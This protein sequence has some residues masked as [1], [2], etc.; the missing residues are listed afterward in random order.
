MNHALF[1]YNGSMGSLTRTHIP[2]IDISIEDVSLDLRL[3]PRRSISDS[4][5]SKQS[6]I[7]NPHIPDAT[8]QVIIA[9]PVIA[10]N[11]PASLWALMMASVAE[12]QHPHE[13]CDRN[14]HHRSEHE[15]DQQVHEQPGEES[16]SGHH[17][18]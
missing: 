3:L 8:A 16:E 9:A 10:S 7:G 5:Q 18:P 11:M 2:F 17:S 12:F 13:E 14:D 15:T 4:P 1:G 6:A